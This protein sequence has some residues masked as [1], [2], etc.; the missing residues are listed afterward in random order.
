M[1]VQHSAMASAPSF[2]APSNFINTRCGDH[3]RPDAMPRK[4]LD[5]GMVQSL[6]L[7]PRTGLTG[8]IVNRCRQFLQ[9]ADRTAS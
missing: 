2:K 7:R 6:G 1:I 5:V 9:V 8:A 3:L 4:L